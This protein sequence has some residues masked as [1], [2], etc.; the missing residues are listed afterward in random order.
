MKKD[1]N[2]SIENRLY[3]VNISRKHT[4]SCQ[5]L[6]SSQS[7]ED[8]FHGSTDRDQFA[9]YFYTFGTVEQQ[10]TKAYTRDF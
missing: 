6:Q 8:T 7:V 4:N 5:A 3:S 9:Q 2:C 1:L 10:W